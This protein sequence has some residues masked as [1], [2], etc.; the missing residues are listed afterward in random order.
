MTRSRVQTNHIQN[1]AVTKPKLASLGQQISSSSGSFTT[2]STSYVTVTNLTV[3]IVTTG[4]PICVGLMP[5]GGGAESYV[6]MARTGGTWSVSWRLLRN[7]NGGGDVAVWT[8]LINTFEDNTGTE[9]FA[10]PSHLFI[11]VQAAASIVYTVQCLSNSTPTLATVGFN[12]VRL[13]AY[14][15]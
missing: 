9:R 1:G 10:V 15:M 14:E 2:T 4:R 11:D 6:S 13:F 12:E 5:A 3:T 8:N 7:V